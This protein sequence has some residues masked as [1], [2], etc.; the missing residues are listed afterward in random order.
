[1]GANKYIDK[2]LA[3]Q[4]IDVLITTKSYDYRPHRALI[5]CLVAGIPRP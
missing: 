2:H 3:P 5:P 4:N 1:M